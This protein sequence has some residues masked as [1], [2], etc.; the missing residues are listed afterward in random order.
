VFT[1]QSGED[2]AR[3]PSSGHDTALPSWLQRAPWPLAASLDWNSAVDDGTSQSR[4]TQQALD[5]HQTSLNYDREQNGV[6]GAFPTSWHMPSRANNLRQN[7]SFA[8][9]R[10]GPISAFL[11][12]FPFGDAVLTY[13]DSGNRLA[14]IHGIN[15][16]F[17]Q[18]ACPV[19]GAA[20][21]G[22][23]RSG[24]KLH[25][26][27]LT[28]ATALPFLRFIYTG[29]YTLEP[30]HTT[31]FTFASGPHDFDDVPTSVLLHCQLYR[32]GDVY[33]LPGLKTQAY[34]NVL[35]QCE[36]GCSSADKP[37][38]LCQAISFVYEHLQDHEQLIDAIVNYCVTCF[39][40]HNLG[41]DPD[42]Q[43]LAYELH[44]F[45]QSLVRCSMSRNFEDESE[46]SPE[47]T[48]AI[49]LR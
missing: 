31:R 5:E 6:P 30:P 9:N 15:A 20:F 10:P 43:R 26:E 37:I 19:L 38:G 21:E 49:G 34:V 46:Y 41:K 47:D 39:N 33:D 12:H 24:P 11:S 44:P 45:N 14:S 27:L 1:D 25:L 18:R 32:L 17:F 28:P 35:K 29:A 2:V 3:P 40:A 22:S 8:L 7:S 36:Y 13:P 42:F 48:T 23:S 4:H 16:T